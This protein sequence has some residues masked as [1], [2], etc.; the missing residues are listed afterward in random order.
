MSNLQIPIEMEENGYEPKDP[1]QN[2]QKIITFEADLLALPQ[3]LLRP[4]LHM[5]ETWSKLLY[6]AL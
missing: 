3:D 5:M 4:R 1:N 6:N 2:R